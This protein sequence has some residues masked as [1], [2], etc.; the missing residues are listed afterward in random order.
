MKL[1]KLHVD[2]FCA[3]LICESMAISSVF[4]AIT[5]NFVGATNPPGGQHH[6]FGTENFELPPL[7]FVPEGAHHPVAILKQRK[8]GVLHMHIDSLVN[9]VVLQCAN[10][11]QAG[12]ITHVREPRILMPSEMS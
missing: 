1:N 4:P 8:N 10:H 5:R 12:A 2:E 11:F 3:G 7:A 6:C 9:A